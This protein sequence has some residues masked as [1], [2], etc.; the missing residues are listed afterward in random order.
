MLS[1]TKKIN[2]KVSPKLKEKH[3][4]NQVTREDSRG[5]EGANKMSRKKNLLGTFIPAPIK[6]NRYY[7]IPNT[8]KNENQGNGAWPKFVLH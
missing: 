1:K 8:D 7:C 3:G 4:P 6:W 2:V 5:S